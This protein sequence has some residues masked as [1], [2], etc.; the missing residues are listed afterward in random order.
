M[1]RNLLIHNQDYI[2]CCLHNNY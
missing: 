2:H 1:L